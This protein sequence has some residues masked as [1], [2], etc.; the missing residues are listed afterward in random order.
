MHHKLKKICEICNIRLGIAVEVGGV[1]V[2]EW[3]N[4]ESDPDHRV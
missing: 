1:A 2:T 4:W 3:K